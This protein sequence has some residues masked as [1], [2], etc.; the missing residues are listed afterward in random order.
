MHV[1][2][3]ADKMQIIFFEKDKQKSSSVIW[4]YRF[5]FQIQKMKFV[6]KNEICKKV[7]TGDTNSGKIAPLNNSTQQPH[8]KSGVP[9]SYER[10]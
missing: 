1:L 7:L 9:T 6:K 3:F 4:E 2:I 5:D 8:K 10:G